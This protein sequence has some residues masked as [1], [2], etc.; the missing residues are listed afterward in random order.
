MK[1][2]KLIRYGFIA[3]GVMMASGIVFVFL[4]QEIMVR[5]ASLCHL[6]PF[7][8]TPVFEYMARGL[9]LVAFLFGL[10]MFYFAFH[11]NEQAH[12]IGLVGWSALALIP[13]AIWIH[14]MA[15]TPLWWKAGDVMGLACLW[16]LCHLSTK[17]NNSKSRGS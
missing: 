13:F 2:G 15:Q 11:L 9:S 17:I 5:I 3:Y 7:E 16:A 12:L 8:I 14:V 10:L 1:K 4:P 6:P